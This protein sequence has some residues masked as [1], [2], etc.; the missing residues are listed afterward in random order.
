MSS[1]S[2]SGF[3][4]L[5]KPPG[6][7]SRDAVDH[8]QKWFPKARLGHAGTLDPAATGVLVIGVGP[9]ATRLIEYIQQQ[10]KVYQSTFALGAISTTDDGDGTLTPL[11]VAAP[12]PRSEVET[13]LQRFVGTI[14][15]TP[16][17]FSAALVQGQ[18][19]YTRARRGEDVTLSAR[20]VTVHRLDLLRYEY[21]ELDVEITCGKGTYI[22]S[23]ARDL[24]AAVKTGAY[25]ACLRRT[26]IGRF[27]VDQ[28]VPWDAD[29]EAAWT[30]LHPLL[31]G[32]PTFPRVEVTQDELARLRQGQWLRGERPSLP[33]AGELALLA[34]ETLVGLGTY[35]AA[36]VFCD[37]L[38][39]SACR[40]GPEDETHRS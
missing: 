23:I 13:S 39:C 10:E 21:P 25:V 6:I 38:K 4:V 34:E 15:Q 35:D 9:T 8:A 3:L 40:V 18:R 2:P 37:Q 36:K 28:A 24:G 14:H 7:T 33:A 27:T 11:D 32:L 20:P 5:D 16:P 12:P 1:P 30:A 29:T 31:A 17:A 26:R 22:R 19:A